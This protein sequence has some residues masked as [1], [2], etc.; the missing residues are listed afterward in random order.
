[1]CRDYGTDRERNLY[2]PIDGTARREDK[3]VTDYYYRSDTRNNPST[4][5]TQWDFRPELGDQNLVQA[6]PC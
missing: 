2:T 5:S 1:M 6:S 4:S 3:A